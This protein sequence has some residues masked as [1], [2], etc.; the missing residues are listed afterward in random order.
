MPDSTPIAWD[1]GPPSVPP[2][3][4]GVT[5]Y[6]VRPGS[7]LYFRLLGP[8]RGVWL[9]W[10]GAR[11]LPCT[12]RGDC[13]H[14]ANANPAVNALRWKG[15]APALRWDFIPGGEGKQG[16]IPCVLEI[17]EN[18]KD[19]LAGLEL[20]GQVVELKRPRGRPNARVEASLIDRPANAPLPPPFD[21]EPILMK[22]WGLH[23][24]RSPIAE[25]LGPDDPVPQIIPF[26]PPG[27]DAGKKQG[28]KRK[29]Q[30]A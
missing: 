3:T 20:A 30:G 24:R 4:P 21:V 17:T 6:T 22:L 12:G 11:S 29:E 1:D 13:P 18:V 25:P 16:W 28:K 14:C 8:W 7:T 19:V 10:L 23:R 26:L 27:M 9:H 15:Y 5:V 2:Q